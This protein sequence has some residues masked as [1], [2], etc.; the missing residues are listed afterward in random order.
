[1]FG[2]KLFSRVSAEGSLPRDRVEAFQAA[3]WTWVSP[4]LRRLVWVGVLTAVSTSALV[5][6]AGT[7]AARLLAAGLVTATSLG[8]ALVYVRRSR[9]GRDLAR[10]LSQIVRPSDPEAGARS[11]RALRLW[12]QTHSNEAFGASPALAERFLLDALAS[13]SS[14]LIEKRARRRARLTDALV[15]V[16]LLISLGLAARAGHEI[17]EGLNVAFARNGRAPLAM[18]WLDVTAA[19]A[20]PPSYLR[21]SEHSILFGARLSEPI[22][23]IISVRGY[24]VRSGPALVLT[25]GRQSVDFVQSADGELVAHWTLTR[26]E[27]LGIAARFGPTMVEQEDAVV[28]DA[29]PDQRPVVS[30]ENEGQTVRLGRVPRVELNYRASDDH[31]L[32]QIDLVLRSAERE[33]R[34]TLMRLDGQQREQSGAH[35]LDAA[36]A[37]LKGVRL[38]TLVRIEARDDNNLV[39][40]NW[41]HSGW[42][43]LEPPMP[44]QPE[45]ERMDVLRNVLRGMVEWLAADPNPELVSAEVLRD[46]VEKKQ[47]ALARLEQSLRPGEGWHWPNHVELLL[48]ALGEKLSR[49]GTRSGP[50]S[51]VERATLAL[52]SLVLDLSERDARL[53]SVA[54]ADLADEIVLGARQAAGTESRDRGQRRVDDALVFLRGG[55]HSLRALGLLGHDLANVVRASLTR[56]ERARA[57]SDFTHVQLAAEYLAARLRRPEPSAGSAPT[58]GIESAPMPG[59]TRSRSTASNAHQRIERMLIELQQLQRDHRANLELLE[60]T[61]KASEAEVRQDAPHG[62]ER[63]RADRLR[64]LAE[65]LP[66]MGAEPD[67][68]LSSQVVARE[69]ALGAAESMRSQQNG[70]A[71]ERVRAARDAIAEALLRAGREES[72]DGIDRKTLGLLDEEL[73][74]QARSLEQ[75]L[76]AAR[77][78]TGQRAAQQLGHQV[79]S[80]R[81]LAGRA[82]ALARREQR[83]D[84]VIPEALRRDID[85]A[86][87]YMERASEA[88]S[89]SDGASALDDE[90]RAQALLDRFD[91]QANRG[92]DEGNQDEAPSRPSPMTN[93]GT[94]TPTGDPEAAA[95]FRSRVQKGLSTQAPGELGA[96]IRRYAEGLLR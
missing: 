76:E 22:G 88:L 61:L 94:V 12:R 17:L 60:R 72:S 89:K 53:V 65:A 27:R 50:R 26:S 33:D 42:I 46:L 49:S 47:V 13:V 57:A 16:G 70:D 75:R 82:R 68:A 87:D 39:A 93:R 9:Q 43:T 54:M 64:R 11:L 78:E 35:A 38:P 84:S 71:L 90:Q 81:E 15:I 66:Y 34:R 25:N 1:M 8:L 3:F 7:P 74:N 48:S 4:P 59:S 56:I 6:R 79:A 14:E 31:G 91:S 80:E 24:P 2:A 85:R 63:E 73:K 10:V 83:K 32:R 44:G 86:A 67:S 62:D 96:A 40:N 21:I 77:N 28:I 95:R 51:T 29:E 52:D 55:A 69:Q 92:R 37:L 20:R 5:A 30:L 36:D 58:G 45:A 41:G 23:T 18:F 19:S